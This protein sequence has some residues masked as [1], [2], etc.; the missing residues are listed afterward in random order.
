MR[1]EFACLGG[2]LFGRIQDRNINDTDLTRVPPQ[3]D[4]RLSRKRV[5]PPFPRIV[6]GYQPSTTWM[7]SGRAIWQR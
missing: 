7:R 3:G 2:R 6:T 1:R 4:R 5:F